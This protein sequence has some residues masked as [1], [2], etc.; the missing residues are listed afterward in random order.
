MDYGVVPTGFQRKRLPEILAELEAAMVANFGPGVIQTSQ[1]PLGQLNGMFADISS[2][3]WEVAEDAYQSF[4]VDQAFGPRLDMLA[5]LRRMARSDGEGDA[6]FQSR[7]TNQGQADIRLTANISRLAA[8]SGVSFAWAIENATSTTSALGMPPHSVAY[9]VL[10][11]DD[12]TI[13]EAV[14][15]LSVPGI[16]LVGNTPISIVADGFC[17]VVRFIRPV[18]V[19]VRVEVDVRAIPSSTGCAPPNVGVLT[20]RLIA[21]FAGG[22]GFKNGEAVT[23]ARVKSEAGKLAALEIVDVRLARV[24]NVIEAD[25]LPMGLY[26]LPVI[27]SPDVVVRYVP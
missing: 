10:G 13:G 3:F 21:A 2:D 15:Q 19:R 1:S 16:E 20:Q 22:L 25:T 5:K 23:K 6:A 26:E 9:S 17:R 7:I 14:Y 24:S 18:L 12:E 8:L 4:D 27:A 11:G